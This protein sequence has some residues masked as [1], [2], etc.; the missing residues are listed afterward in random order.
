MVLTHNPSQQMPSRKS[1]KR[2]KLA[3][4]AQEST[5]CMY[6]ERPNK[7][8]RT[9]IANSHPHETMQGHGKGPQDDAKDDAKKT[10]VVIIPGSGCF[11]VDDSNWYR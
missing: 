8:G 3:S 7:I 4:K 9:H 10:K 6:C 2:G 1:R 5:V 11:P